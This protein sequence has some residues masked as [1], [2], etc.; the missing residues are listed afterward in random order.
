[1]TELL[2]SFQ[3]TTLADTTTFDWHDVVGTTIITPNTAFVISVYTR[4]ECDDEKVTR[5]ISCTFI[6]IVSQNCLCGCDVPNVVSISYNGVV[7]VIF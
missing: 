3:R 1:M 4:C 7:Q 5:E 2:L 6:S